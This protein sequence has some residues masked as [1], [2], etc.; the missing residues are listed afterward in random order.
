MI[1]FCFFQ[2]FE[3]LVPVDSRERTTSRFSGSAS[4]NCRSAR[5]ASYCARSI[6]RSHCFSDSLFVSWM[7]R[8]TFREISSSEGFMMERIFRRLHGQ[9]SQQ[10]RK[11]RLLYCHA[12]SG[13]RIRIMDVCRQSLYNGPTYGGR[14]SRRPGCLQEGQPHHGRAAPFRVCT[15]GTK[16]ILVFLELFPG[17]ISR[18]MAGRKTFQSFLSGRRTGWCSKCPSASTV[19]L[20]R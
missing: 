17:D 19:L 10:G 8:M 9:E 6:A 18:M 3:F 16:A 15:V 20:S 5:S 11:N 7:L 1:L 13:Q 12:P 14:I 2:F 4:I